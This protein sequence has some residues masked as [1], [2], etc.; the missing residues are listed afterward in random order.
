VDAT[1]RQGLDLYEKREYEEAL[2]FLL[3]AAE[4][5][6]K[7]GMA[8]LG[9]MYLFGRGV[10]NDAEKATQWLAGV[11]SGQGTGRRSVDPRYHVR[12]WARGNKK[13]SCSEKMA[14]DSVRSR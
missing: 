10:E 1:Y 7:D 5:G 8:V 14:Y 2:P 4:A 9:A 12:D 6:H 11:S 3:E 13:H